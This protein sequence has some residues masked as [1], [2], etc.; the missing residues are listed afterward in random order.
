MSEEQNEILAEQQYILEHRMYHL[1]PPPPKLTAQEYIIRYLT[2]KEDKYLR[3][4]LHNQEPA[5]N[6]IAQ[7]VCERYAMS[8]HFADIKQ[9]AVFGI[10]TALQKYDPT[11]GAPF[12]A[13]QK[14]YI[15]DSIDDYIRTAQSGVVT[16]TADTYPI[17]RRIMAI[18]HQNGD[19]CGNDSIQKIS[20]EIGMD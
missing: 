14:Q 18:Y 8:E 5:I 7:A 19:D 4:Y 16:M 15:K 6:K 10:L 9:A 13:F 17:L 12:T 2:E 11:I 1:D 3:W 20:D